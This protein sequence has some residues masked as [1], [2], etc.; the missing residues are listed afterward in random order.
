MT[1]IIGCAILLFLG[2]A[3]LFGKIFF[4]NEYDSDKKFVK[5]AV[6]AGILLLLGIAGGI[7]YYVKNKNE[8]KMIK[9]CDGIKYDLE[10]EKFIGRW[11]TDNAFFN[12]INKDSIKINYHLG[13]EYIGSWRTEGSMIF[14]KCYNGSEALD[15]R[16]KICIYKSKKFIFE[17]IE[18]NNQFT[19][20]KL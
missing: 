12:F 20:T 4:I 7:Y 5:G 15:L 9:M 6:M 3:F 8:E 2:V 11:E 16:F 13:G 10:P 1:I 17:D 14:I 19:A 18:D